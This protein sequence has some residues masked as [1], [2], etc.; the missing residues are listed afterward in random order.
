MYAMYAISSS[1]DF[2]NIETH[3]IS[4]YRVAQIM[5]FNITFTNRKI[6]KILNNVDSM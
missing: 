1:F 3:L 6:M 2:L 5:L 4:R